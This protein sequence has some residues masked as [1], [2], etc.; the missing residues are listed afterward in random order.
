MIDVSQDGNAGHG[1]VGTLEWFELVDA[2]VL[3]FS[4]TQVSTGLPKSFSLKQSRVHHPV[5][6]REKKGKGE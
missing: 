1:L 4:L 5:W 2:G 3:C 6:L